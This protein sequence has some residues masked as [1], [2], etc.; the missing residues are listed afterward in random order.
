V[1]YDVCGTMD[2]SSGL[3]SVW[4]NGVLGGTNNPNP[5]T[6][7]TINPN[8]ASTVIGM[9][10]SNGIPG[11]YFDGDIAEA[12]IWNVILSPDEIQSLSKGFIPP[13]IRPQNLVFY[14]PLIGGTNDFRGGIPLANFNNV[15]VSEHPRRIG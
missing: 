1:W 2:I 12:G 13:R 5:G 15:L 6:T 10:M 7:Q 4:I 3:I 14:A 11:L 9:R 8:T